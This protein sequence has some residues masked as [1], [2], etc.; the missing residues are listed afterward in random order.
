MAPA[1]RTRAALLSLVLLG[2]GAGCD[3]GAAVEGVVR[4]INTDD[5]IAEV[6]VGFLQL[7]GGRLELRPDFA[8]TTDT[9]GTWDM[10]TSSGPF[11]EGFLTFSHGLYVADTVHFFGAELGTTGQITLF[12]IPL[13]E[14]PAPSAPPENP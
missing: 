11:P 6:A 5:P 12:M 7:Q 14:S 2:A 4:D 3:D 8:A 13:E 10:A 9:S 1:E